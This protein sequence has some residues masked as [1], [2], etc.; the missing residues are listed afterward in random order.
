MTP[1]LYYLV[2]LI[3]F[4]GHFTWNADWPD[5]RDA[6]GAVEEAGKLELGFDVGVVI[7]DL[8]VDAAVSN[9]GVQGRRVDVA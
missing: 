8:A 6:E 4:A 1:P 5:I 2:S 3:W 7:E 9:D